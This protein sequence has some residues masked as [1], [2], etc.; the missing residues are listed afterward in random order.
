MPTTSS[1]D[2]PPPSSWEDFEDIC[3]DIW[4]EVWGDRNLQR[5]G[6]QGQAQHGVD[7]FGTDKFGAIC[8]AQCKGKQNWPTKKLTVKE[9]DDEVQKAKSFPR[10]LS[11]YI[12]LTTAAND[13]PIQDHVSAINDNSSNGIDFRVHVYFWS[14]IKRRLANYPQL[15][16]K[17][18][19]KY[20]RTA[21]NPDIYD[22][23]ANRL[24]KELRETR[25]FGNTKPEDK[26]IQL[27]GRI[28]SS[29]LREASIEVRRR[30]LAWCARLMAVRNTVKAE[31]FLTKAKSMGSCEDV[32]IASAFIAAAKKQIPIALANLNR[33]GSASARSAALM[34]KMNDEG[35]EKALGWSDASGLRW[36]DYDDDGRT[37]LILAAAEIGDWRRLEK[38]VEKVELTDEPLLPALASVSAKGTL[39]LTLPEEE[40]SSLGNSPPFFTHNLRLSST[41]S[42]LKL[43]RRAIAL[44]QESADALRRIGLDQTALIQE[45]FALWLRLADPETRSECQSDLEV[46]LR[47]KELRMRR[48]NLA[49][50]YG[51]KLDRDLLKRDI[52]QEVARNS[53]GNVDTG[54]AALAIALTEDSPE[55]AI[56]EFR[57]RKDSISE[58]IAPEHVIGIEI[59]LLANAGMGAEARR[60]QSENQNILS[61]ERTDSLD[62]LIQVAEGADPV[63]LLQHQYDAKGDLL[64][65][66][67]L[68][69]ALYSRRSWEACSAFSSEFFK[70]TKNILDAKKHIRVLTEIKKFGEVL[71]LLESHPE[72]K[73]DFEL[74]KVQV[75]SFLETGRLAESISSAEV[76]LGIEDDAEVRRM[77]ANAF[78]AAGDWEKLPLIIEK[79]WDRCDDLSAR[80]LLQSA[81]LAQ[82]IG[83]SREKELVRAAVA[84]SD[85]DGFAYA[86]A[87]Y[88]AN[89]GGWEDNDE[90]GSWLRR[91][92]DLSD[93]NGPMY[94]ADIREV[95]GKQVDWNRHSQGIFDSLRAAQTPIFIAAI[96]L[97]RRLVDFT[98]SRTIANLNQRKIAQRQVIPSFSGKRQSAYIS[99][100]RIGLEATS[101]LNLHT[102]GALEATLK[103]YEQVCV[104]H[105]TMTWL[106][107]EVS[108][109]RFQQPSRI[110]R[111]EALIQHILKGSITV[112]DTKQPVPFSLTEEVGDDL[113]SLIISANYG[114]QREIPSV[115]VRGFPIHKA[116]SLGDDNA[117]VQIWEHLFVSTEAVVKYLLENSHI[118]DTAAKAAN[119]FLQFQESVWPEVLDLQHDMVLYL[120]GVTVSHLQHLGLLEVL[121][122]SGLLIVISNDAYSEVQALSK[123]KQHTRTIEIE[124]N[125]LRQVLNRHIRSGDIVVLPNDDGH[126]GTENDRRFWS[127]PTMSAFNPANTPDAIIVDD[128]FLNRHEQFDGGRA[129]TKIYNSLDVLKTLH[130]N[131]C[132]SDEKYYTSLNVLREGGHMF[133][134][135]ESSELSFLLGKAKI[136]QDNF[137][138]SRELRSIKDYYM[139]ARICEFITIPDD[140]HW[141]MNSNRVVN[142]TIKEQWVVGIDFKE[143]KLRSE[144]LFGLVDMRMWGA[145]NDI[146][147]GS[148]PTDG[149]WMAN[150]MGLLSTPEGASMK[151]RNAYLAWLDE[152]IIRP[153]KLKHPKI[154]SEIVRS[155]KE[156]ITNMVKDQGGFNSND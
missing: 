86:G 131:K 56:A 156:L 117:D 85:K 8:A 137:T 79:D 134:P 96:N 123:L 28:C 75:W 76:A 77:L 151:E 78:V 67:N 64:S 152:H 62:R 21:A 6:R 106:L 29:D 36:E 126:R 93:E 24:L 51:V 133:V 60:I 141:L 23:E 14:E 147:G 57:K 120:D 58:A 140:L 81:H 32:E 71:E 98:L 80:D 16:E 7:F 35:F 113:A 116:S 12:I 59:E 68:V 4:T 121:A 17:H 108:E 132:L 11:E 13:G 111:A 114:K 9:I 73:D 122:A 74:R 41:A 92:I 104:P 37:R 88:L 65:L 150:I 61:K 91:A 103:Y 115:I 38:Y 124:L 25:F 15:L 102:V 155:S 72:F 145:D 148:N 31:E 90:V 154:F 129:E 27:A 89:R 49:F 70:R 22:R 139:L 125:N 30:C 149:F 18:Y 118:T 5:Y 53:G 94:P 153:L 19:P 1:I 52:D 99:F 87:Y 100:K 50:Q 95:I 127:H 84:K 143:A 46:Q 112:C 10:A 54:C 146:V 109:V 135:L 144:W 45:D 142:N 44:Y 82:T 39:L 110:E 119:E 34:I 2:L 48:A 3:A 101:L 105:S 33:L 69:E 128:R 42:A 40:R 43:R 55:E 47:S 66:L 130:E 136:K 63:S 138:P 83:H 107:E 97:N 26:A 20:F